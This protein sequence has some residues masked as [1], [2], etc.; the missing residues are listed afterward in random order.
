MT[1]VPRRVKW[2]QQQTDEKTDEAGTLIN[3]Q[4]EPAGIFHGAFFLHDL[5]AAAPSS[6]GSS[7]PIGHLF[8]IPPLV[9]EFFFSF[10]KN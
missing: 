2:R 1:E 4:K 10:V 8:N 6:G 5:W 3:R 9:N 7:P